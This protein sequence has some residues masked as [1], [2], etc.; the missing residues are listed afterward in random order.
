M[1]KRY[2][3][4]LREERRLV[5]LR[6]LAELPEYRANSSTLYA[7]LD[8]MAVPATR[9][10][11]KTD[12]AWLAEQDLVTT[13]PIDGLPLVIATI[14]VRGLDVAAGKAV[15]PGVKRPGPRD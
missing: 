3:E 13:V 2:A 9:D 15:V 7:G 8:A 1:T 5:L 11:V 6:L 4:F 14:T 12:L 10:D